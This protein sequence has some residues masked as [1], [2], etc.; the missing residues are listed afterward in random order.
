MAD[1][2]ESKNACHHNIGCI[3]TDGSGGQVIL[4]AFFHKLGE[5][6]PRTNRT[7]DELF[8][9]GSEAEI[10]S[11][12]SR[13]RDR[14]IS[15]WQDA[16]RPP[17]PSRRSGRP[18]Y[19]EVRYAAPV[20]GSD[21]SHGSSG[22][23]EPCHRRSACTHG[24]SPYRSCSSWASGP[25][26]LFGLRME[27][28]EGT[29]MGAAGC[30]PTRRSAATTARPASTTATT[31][32]HASTPTFKRTRATPCRPR[33]TRARRCEQGTDIVI[34]DA[35]R[36]LIGAVTAPDHAIR[37][38]CDRPI[39]HRC[40]KPKLSRR[41]RS[42]LRARRRCWRACSWAL[43]AS[44]SRMASIIPRCSRA[45]RSSFRRI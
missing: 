23:P 20:S 43:L 3:E 39:A 25:H 19:A 31:A 21:G 36:R 22:N 14:T 11:R 41:G 28:A 6:D 4:N 1:R 18:I 17:V 45:E 2:Q 12:R 10:C 44:P 40:F 37:R 7:V 15:P 42:S 33:I 9:T 30:R 24:G 29:G 38:A 27:A 13:R 34:G 35:K 26:L 5:S 32:I 16:F 8:T